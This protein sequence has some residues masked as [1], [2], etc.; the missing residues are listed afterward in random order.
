MPIITN[1]ATLRTS[2]ADWLNRTDLLDSTDQ[3]DQFIEMGEAKIYEV[4]RVPPLEKLSSFTVLEVN[5]SITLPSG[6][7]ELISLEKSGDSKDDNIILSRVDEKTFANNKVTNAYIRVGSNLLLTDSS[8]EQKASGTYIL[9]YYKADEPIGTTP[10]G[11]SEITTQF[12]LD[13]EYEA[14]LFAT[15]S[16]ASIYLGDGEA[17]QKYNELFLRKVNSLNAKEKAASLKGGQFSASIPYPG[18]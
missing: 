14:I 4:L 12:I 5:S 17:E 10:A 18:I 15:L 1:Q 7:I 8:G 2:V 16:V 13:T 9:R 6:F 11:G 3:L